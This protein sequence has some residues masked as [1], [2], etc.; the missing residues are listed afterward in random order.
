MEK[1]VRKFGMW[2]LVTRSEEIEGEW[3]AD[4]PDL[5]FTAQGR[6]PTQAIDAAYEAAEMV[7]LNDLQHGRDPYG[8]R[9]LEGQRKAIVD[10]LYGNFDFVIPIDEIDGRT[11]EFSCLGIAMT[12][13]FV[14][15]VDHVPLSTNPVRASDAISCTA[16]PEA[17]VHAE[18]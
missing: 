8:R 9:S 2:I 10:I 16:P 17:P 18:A 15:Q 4:V 12:L 1:E 11:D 7:I 13:A 6:S 3:L 5:G 14:R